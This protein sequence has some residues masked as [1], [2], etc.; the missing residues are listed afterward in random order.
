MRVD[1]ERPSSTSRDDA[2][3]LRA[4]AV[5]WQTLDVPLSNL[6]RVGHERTEVEVGVGRNVQFRYLHIEGEIETVKI[7][8]FVSFFCFGGSRPHL[9]DPEFFDE[10]VAIV[11]E[12]WTAVAEEG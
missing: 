3:V 8:N 7:R 9:S 10:V 2:S 1:H 5:A 4:E 6:G 11:G 12:E